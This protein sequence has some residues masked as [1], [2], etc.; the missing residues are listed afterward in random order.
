MILNFFIMGGYGIYVWSAF[1]FAFLVCLLLFVRTRKTLKKLEKEFNSEAT[2]LTEGQ[3]ETLKD[4]K[5][6]QQILNSQHKIQ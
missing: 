3:L 6:I 5:A 2:K 1:I 4:R